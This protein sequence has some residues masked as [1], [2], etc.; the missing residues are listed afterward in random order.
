MT[1]LY[2]KGVRMLTDMETEAE[3]TAEYEAL[4]RED[5]A[6]L[7]RVQAKCLWLLLGELPI[8]SARAAAL[9]EILR[10]ERMIAALQDD[11]VDN[12]PPLC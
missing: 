9:E 5:I 3:E 10:I 1:T 6:M 8:T 7:E 4:V 11:L 12:G 2:D